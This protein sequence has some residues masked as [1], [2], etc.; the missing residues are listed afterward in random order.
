MRIDVTIS[1][2]AA[3]G[4]RGEPGV[5]ELLTDELAAAQAESLPI[6][7][8]RAYVNAVALAADA[9]DHAAVDVLAARAI[10]QLDAYQSAIPRE[11]ISLSLAQSLLDRGRWDEAL[12]QVARGRRSLHGG[13]PVAL[14]IEGRVR[15]RRGE[16][17]AQ[18]LL[19]QAWDGVAK[20]PPSW[21]HGQIRAALAEAAWLRGDLSAARAHA[22]AGLNAPY[23]AQLARSSGELALWASR[24]GEAVEPPANAAVPVSYEL[25]GDWRGALRAWRELE[26]PYEA[27]LAALPGDERAAR[28]AMSALQRL[29]ATA[30]ARAFARTRTERG[31]RAPRGPRHSTL[32]NP[33]GLTRRELEVLAELAGGATNA[34]IAGALH[35][36]ER[37]VAHHVS[38][39]LGKLG[40]HTRTAAVEA[41]RRTGLLAEDGQPRGPT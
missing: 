35:L 40:A 3:R 4:H 10:A 23:A 39:I 2:G 27:A 12:E 14:A 30:A 29:G 33:A 41:A 13:I 11:N 16:P 15:A 37:T 21:R 24:C 18:E 34:A 26:A 36:S 20:I 32:A 1:L 28:E 25:A 5:L 6:Q 19:E 38:S 9:R 31:A 22:L 7:T 8:I 17:G